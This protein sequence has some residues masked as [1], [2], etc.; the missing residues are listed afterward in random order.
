MCPQRESVPVLREN[1]PV[2]G[3]VY[4]VVGGLESPVPWAVVIVF[5]D[6]GRRLFSVLAKVERRIRINRPD[7]ENARCKASRVP[8]Q[9]KYFSLL[10]SSPQ[11]VVWECFR[12][13]ILFSIRCS[14]VK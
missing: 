6:G 11:Y 9:R 7:D 8:V 3:I 12:Q 14:F 5:V 1:T 4:D 10:C 13:A 2:D